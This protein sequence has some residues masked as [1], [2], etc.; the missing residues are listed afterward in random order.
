MKHHTT[1]HCECELVRLFNDLLLTDSKTSVSINTDSPSF[2]VG[3]MLEKKH[4]EAKRINSINLCCKVLRYKYI[5]AT[6]ELTMWL[7][8]LENLSEEKES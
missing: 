6:M 2:I 4:Y 7:L 1:N 8:D 5:P 3:R